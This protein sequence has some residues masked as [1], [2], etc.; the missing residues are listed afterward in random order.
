MTVRA[1]QLFKTKPSKQLNIIIINIIIAMQRLISILIIMVNM[2]ATIVIIAI[3]RM[4]IM[5]RCTKSCLINISFCA[6]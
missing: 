3:V 6:A 5:M 2:G 1:A 4:M